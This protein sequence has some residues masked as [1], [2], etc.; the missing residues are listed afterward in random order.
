MGPFAKY[1]FDY[2]PADA[3]LGLRP[4]IA[5]L[6][7]FS[8]LLIQGKSL[9][10]SRASVPRF[11]FCGA[12]GF[13]LTQTSYVRSL[14][15]TSVSHHAVLISTTPLLAAIFMPIVRRSRPHGLVLLGSLIGFLGV[16]MLVGGD[17]GGGATIKGD[18]LALTSAVIWIGV[19]VWPLPLM[20]RYDVAKANAWL[21]AMSL[22]LIIPLTSPAL[23]EVA[24]NPPNWIAWAAVIYGGLIGILLGNILWFRAIQ[25]AGVDRILVYQYL[26]PV[27]TLA[28]A[29]I[30]LGESIS[31]GQALGSILVLAGVVVVQRST[32]RRSLPEPDLTT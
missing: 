13:A 19:V 30:F 10:I 5:A 32:P 25:Q 20:A 27:L 31:W 7:G 12:I 29:L 4:A 23:V 14:D 11:F 17:S 6:G 24:R 28:I 16:V 8:L 3:Y 22:I 9:G 18:L 26:P 21:F 1:A 15:M 2:F